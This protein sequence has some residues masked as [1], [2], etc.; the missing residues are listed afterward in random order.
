MTRAL[1]VSS[2]PKMRV[3]VFIDRP[4]VAS[5]MITRR[6]ALYLLSS[7]ILLG[8]IAHAQF[9]QQGNKLVGAGATLVACQG[10]A[11]AVS[12]DGNTAIVG[13]G[14]DGPGGPDSFRLG[15]AWIYVRA[16]GLWTQQGPKLVGTGASGGAA[17]GFAVSISAD[18][19][20]ALVGGFA[21]TLV[22]GGYFG[23][24]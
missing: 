21:D 13:G 6:F 22:A 14:C 23:A 24:A 12:A 7:A 15:A 9:V 8:P 16:N 3:T 5:L 10:A 1:C 18:G 19:N 11:V 2:G 20:T 4:K 17:Q